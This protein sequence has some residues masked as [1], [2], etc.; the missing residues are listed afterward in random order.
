[1]ENENG[2]DDND[3]TDDEDDEE[4][5][6]DVNDNGEGN[7]HPAVKIVPGNLPALA[8]VD[9]GDS[10]VFLRSTVCTF[11]L[12]GSNQVHRGRAVVRAN[13]FHRR[14]CRWLPLLEATR[15]MNT[16]FRIS[17]Y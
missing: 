15:A 17:I 6:Y 3:D 11:R 13:E 1:M 16:A 5:Q 4:M 7:N 12:H 2:K 8:G 14:S 9:E 10:I